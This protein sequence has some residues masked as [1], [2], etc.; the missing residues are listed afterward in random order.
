[1]VKA[2]SQDNRQKVQAYFHKLKEELIQEGDKSSVK[3]HLGT[4]EWNELKTKWES[5]RVNAVNAV[6]VEK[7]AKKDSKESCGPFSVQHDFTRH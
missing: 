3:V 6:K 2:M 1:M 4:A 5:F 7:A